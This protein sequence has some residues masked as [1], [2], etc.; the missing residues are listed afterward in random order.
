MHIFMSKQEQSQ[1]LLHHRLAEII[2]QEVQLDGI[3]LTVGFVDLSP[4]LKQAKI[5]ISVLP[6]KFYGTALEKLRKNTGSI[7]SRLAKQL[8]W[9]LV[10]RLNWEIDSR[11]KKAAELEEVFKQI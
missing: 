5:G 11:P 7:R 3:L 4:D 6:D 2:N 8:N 9:R 10:P 1:E